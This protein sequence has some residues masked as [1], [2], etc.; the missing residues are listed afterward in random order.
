MSAVTQLESIEATLTS[1]TKDHQSIL[2]DLNFLEELLMDKSDSPEKA[3]LV[4]KKL[5]MLLQGDHHQR[6]ESVLYEWM[7]NQ[8]VNVDQ[9]IITRIRKEHDD[10][11]S[12]MERISQQVQLTKV[13]AFDIRDFID[14]YRE[15]I[16]LED[17][18]IF[19]I[20]KGLISRHRVS[21]NG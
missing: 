10:L 9:D 5:R 3:L 12:L 6:E 14:L 1:L 4:F 17:K 20:A 8:N 11:E 2:Q 15:H 19:Q 21:G 13:A 18:F 16:D 7:I